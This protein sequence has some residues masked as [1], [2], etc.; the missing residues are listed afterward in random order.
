MKMHLILVLLLSLTP[1]AWAE[2]T[3]VSRSLLV[4]D[5]EERSAAEVLDSLTPHLGS[6][7]AVSQ[8]GQRLLISG[9]AP[10]LEGLEALIAA[11]DQRQEEYRLLFSKGRQDFE[12]QQEARSRRYSTSAN[13][14][15]R[16]H[17]MAEVPAR[18]ERGFWVPVAEVNAWGRQENYQWMAGGVWVRAQQQGDDVILE[19]TS[20]D[21]NRE[22]GSRVVSPVMFSGSEVETRIRLQPGRWQTLASEGQLRAQGSER[23]RTYS[24]RRHETYYSVCLERPQEQITCPFQ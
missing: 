13:E 9:P 8:Q 6:E 23:G 1:L 15:T 2:S 21:L 17:L 11:L 14:L 12:D 20:R 16:L 24:T 3:D 5:L 19:F 18:L 22:R 10:Q 4:Y 7:V